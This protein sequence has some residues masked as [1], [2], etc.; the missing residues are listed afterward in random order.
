MLRVVVCGGG[1]GSELVADYL[2]AELGIIEVIRLSDWRVPDYSALSP[3]ERIERVEFSLSSYA[4]KPD[5][6]VLGDYAA[7]TVINQLIER[8][9]HLNFVGMSIDSNRILRTRNYPTDIVILADRSFQGSPL[10]DTLFKKIPDSS[11]RIMECERWI[12]LINSQEITTSIIRQDLE[13]R[14]KLRKVSS[15]STDGSSA[16]PLSAAHSVK[17]LAS[18]S[19]DLFN[20][21][22]VLL[23]NTY[24]WDISKELEKVFDWRVRILD[25]R[26][27]LLHDVCRALRLRGVDGCRAR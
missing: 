9:P 22:T 27:Q 14:L 15:K 4:K 13:K 6:I 1:W 16:P 8:N 2:Q 19:D 5:L 17:K 10:Q 18:L 11:F 23:L 20:P 26:K 12:E 7:S 25:F 3:M 21:D 24:Y